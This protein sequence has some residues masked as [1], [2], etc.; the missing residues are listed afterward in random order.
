MTFRRVLRYVLFFTPLLVMPLLVSASIDANST[1]LVEAGRAAGLSSICS[2]DASACIATLVGKFLNMVLG[3]IGLILFLYVVYGGFLYMSAGG[4]DKQVKMAKDTLQNAVV[5]VFLVVLAF[6]I[7][8]FVLDRAIEVTG[9]GEAVGGSGAGTETP[10]SP[11]TNGTNSTN[12]TGGDTGGGGALVCNCEC[13]IGGIASI[14]PPGSITGACDASPSGNCTSACTAACTRAGGVPSSVGATCSATSLEDTRVP[15]ARCETTSGVGVAPFGAT[16]RSGGLC[17]YAQ[18]QCDA[19][20]REVLMA[21]CTRAYATPGTTW[22][23]TQ[24]AIAQGNANA[25]CGAVCN[26]NPT[27][28]ATLCP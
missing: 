24:I 3:F 6:G 16:I 12:A 19:C 18:R 2:S 17:S 13:R 4:D 28:Y 11:S 1:G 8:S 23:T 22:S 26:P 9:G 21:A 5:G 27:D 25:S 14:V 20:M 15:S 7:S 10:G